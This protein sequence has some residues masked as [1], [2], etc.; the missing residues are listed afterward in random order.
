MATAPNARTR[1]VGDAA[2]VVLADQGARGLTHR[3]VDRAAGLPPGT[4]SNHAR[5]RAALLTLALARIAELEAAETA[6]GTGGQSESGY[7][8]SE[9][10]GSGQSGSGQSGSGLSGSGQSGSG[11]SGSG[12]SGLGVSGEELAD[13]LAIVLDRWITDPGAR[14]RVLARFELALEATRRPELRAAYDEVG[15]V[16]RGQAVQLLAISGSADPERDAWTLIAWMEGTVFYAL[17]GA[18]AAVSPAL[19]VLRDQLG[20]LLATMIPVARPPAGHD[21]SGAA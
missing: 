13:A 16:I 17:A 12:L 5:T 4:T 10:S 21:D 15:R 14:R 9:I 6:S 18:G 3:A 1:Q 20:R 11:Q 8:G 19:D 2:I 7:S